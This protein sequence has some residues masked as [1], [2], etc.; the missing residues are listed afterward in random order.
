[1]TEDWVTYSIIILSSLDLAELVKRQDSAAHAT[2]KFFSVTT[3]AGHAIDTLDR[4][5]GVSCMGS[6]SSLPLSEGRARE[7]SLRFVLVARPALDPS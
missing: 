2:L 1:M 5:L 3:T 4:L 6:L 7:H